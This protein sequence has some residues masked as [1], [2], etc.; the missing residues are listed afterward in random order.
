MTENGQLELGFLKRAVEVKF[1]RRLST[2]A[3]FTALSE[4]MEERISPSTLKRLWGYVGMV[5]TPRRSSLDALSQFVGYKDYRAFCSSLRES[6]FSASSYFNAERLDADTLQPGDRFQI[7]WRPD[8]I[9]S[10][11]Y[12]GDHHFRVL[13]SIHSKLQEGDIFEANAIIKGFPLV[14]PWILRD[15]EKTP[16]YIAGREGGIIIIKED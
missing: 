4:E 16:S 2:T 5:V 11:E 8:R 10:L 7:G 13:N 12:Q 3:D 9:V 15:G 14:L 1:D 6:S